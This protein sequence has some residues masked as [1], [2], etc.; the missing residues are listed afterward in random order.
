MNNNHNPIEAPDGVPPDKLRWRWPLGRSKCAGEIGEFRGS[1]SRN[2]GA[3]SMIGAKGLEQKITKV[4]KCGGREPSGDSGTETGSITVQCVLM[5]KALEP[6]R[7]L[8]SP[9]EFG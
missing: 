6:P 3:E 5:E 2:G 9:S 7:P 8:R 1:G 4:T